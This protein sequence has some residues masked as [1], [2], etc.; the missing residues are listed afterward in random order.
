MPFQSKYDWKRA[1]E[2]YDAGCN[3]REIA[4]QL[5]ITSTVSVWAWRNRNNYPSNV[6]KRDGQELAG[7][8]RKLLDRG[9]SPKAI[10]YRLG[11][12]D[13][14]V[15]AT[16]RRTTEVNRIERQRIEDKHRE[17]IGIA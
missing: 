14:Y 13:S 3:D 10:A 9:L 17:L 15:R 16:R 2:L 7:K 8:I 5:G 1:K 4:R 12:S 6:I 11:T